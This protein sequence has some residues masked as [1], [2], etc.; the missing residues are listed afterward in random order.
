VIP[1]LQSTPGSKPFGVLPGVQP[2]GVY[3]PGVPTQTPTATIGATET[4]TESP[5]PSPTFSPTSTI[6]ATMTA[7]STPSATIEALPTSPEGTAAGDT[8]TVGSG[9][10]STPSLTEAS[11]VTSTPTLAASLTPTITRSASATATPGP[12]GTPTS[13]RT[14]SITP[15]NPE[16][17]T[18][19]PT[20][21][22][23]EDLGILQLQN[24]QFTPNPTLIGTDCAPRGLPVY[25]VLTQR[26]HFYH[27]GID[28]GVPTGSPV[29]ATHSGQVI[30]AG[31]S[32]IGYGWLVIIQNGK[33]ITYYAHNS[34]FNVVL[35]QYVHPGDVVAFSGSTGNSSGPHV[36][37][38][39]RINNFPVDPLTFDM[40]S[41]AHC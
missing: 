26:Y 23:V 14:A 32:Y 24:L 37:Y 38:E 22:P 16:T 40:R 28:L 41:L 31:W 11:T 13:T 35:Y 21:Q 10:T 1:A 15:T 29:Y 39:A 5:A 3:L 9:I 12:T 36:H 25:G 4:A 18:P 27:S 2:I 30:F 7:S 33:Y 20:D 19:F 34:R 6:G 8:P 17:P